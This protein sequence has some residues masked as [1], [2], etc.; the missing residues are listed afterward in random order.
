MSSKLNFFT[1]CVAATSLGIFSISANAAE[2][3]DFGSITFVG[4]SITQGGGAG[5]SY[6]DKSVSYRY[7]LWKIFVSNG[8]AWNPVG[9][10][11]TF[12]D[13]S[14]AN[15]TQTPD[16]RG[17]VY[18]NTSEGHYG[19]RTYDFLDGPSGRNANSGSGTL[20]EWLANTSYYSE[21]TPDTVTMLLGVND[22]SPAYNKSVED[23]AANAKSI[24]A[25]YQEKNPGVTVHVFSVLPTNQT[26]NSESSWTKI[27]EY[28]AELKSQIESGAWN[29]E[30]S[31]VMYHDITAGFDAVAFTSD[32]V[33]PNAAGAFLVARNIATALGLDANIDLGITRKEASALATQ[34]QFS[35][36][37]TSITATAKTGETG[38]AF[39]VTSATGHSW[40]AE[41]SGNLK[42][43]TTTSGASDIRLAW[44]EDSVPQDFT[45]ELSVKMDKTEGTE[46]FLGVFLGNGEDV[47]ILYIG[48]SGIFWNGTS[49][50]NLLYGGYSDEYKTYFATEDYVDLRVVYLSDTTAT[51]I[52]AGYYVWLNGEL[53]GDCLSGTTTESVITSYKDYLLIGDIGSSYAVNASIESLS[54]ETGIAYQPLSVP[55][56]SAFGLLAG[57]G[58]LALVASRRRRK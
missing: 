22:L 1:L 15:S 21:G 29:T 5:S 12:L 17:H 13:G 48:E 55:E 44:V 53:I 54:F 31:S 42:I 40:T 56:P 39:T 45:L 36:S 46:N 16:F 27:Q 32:N 8:V 7:S 47:G 2:S 20:A 25:Q 3:L 14:S 11:T 4:D 43:E 57:L 9:S 6:T 50:G 33:H 23:T 41:D 37:G 34:T 19:W 10:M 52:A 30:T 24:I 28:N 58:A 18:D 51:D 26:W 38:T 35:S 49:A